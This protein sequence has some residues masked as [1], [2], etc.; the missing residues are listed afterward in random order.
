MDRLMDFASPEKI[1]EAAHSAGCASVAFTYNDPVIF[2]E[3]AMDTA[4][5]CHDRDVRTVAVTAGYIEADARP[6]FFSEIDAVNVDLKAFTEQFYATLC[7]AHLAPVL[8]TLRW[9]RRESE[10]WLE[11]TTLLI[12]GENDSE[13]EVERLVEFVVE[14][15]G[16]EVP[17][18]FSAY[19]PDFKFRAVGPT[20]RA[21][22]SRAREQAKA[23][24]L[25]HVY[26]GNV[27]DPEGE[28]TYCASCDGVLIER[29]RY[30][31]RSYRLDEKGRCP[32]CGAELAGVFGD[33]PGGGRGGRQ[34]LRIA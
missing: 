24:G 7:F 33:G 28:T 32:G 6:A 14:E 16:P 21:T 10:T 22:L 25:R 23:A 27:H 26:T 29:D 8:D 31:L 1:A 30:R 12:P 34:R 13:D 5:A 18:H 11:V 2:A 17:L 3:Y 19:H 9:I 15:L 20:P 4:L